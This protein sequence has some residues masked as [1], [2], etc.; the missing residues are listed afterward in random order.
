MQ[1]A[2]YDDEVGYYARPRSPLGA[3]GDYF[4]SPL[5]HPAFA[6]LLARQVRELWDRLGRPR[7]FVL[8]ESG[9]GNGLFARDLLDWLRA[10]EPSLYYGLLYRLD[11]RSPARRREQRRR[12][13]RAEHLERAAW[14]QRFPADPPAH[15]VFANELLDAL[16]VHLVRR[17]DGQP[18]E[19]YVGLERDRLVLVSGPLSTDRLA[20]Y[21]DRLGL[22]PAE[23][24]QAEVNL[25]A[26]DWLESAARGL[27]SGLLLV[28]DY[29]YPAE[30]LYAA[31]RPAGT[32]LSY[33]RHTLGSDPLVRVG[34]QDLTSH[35][36]FTSLRLTAEQA[37]LTTLGLISQRRLLANLGL[38]ELFERTA[39]ADLPQA[40]RD[41]NL[42]ALEALVE[43][44]GL[45]RVLAYFAVKQLDDYAPLGLI[46]AGGRWEPPGLPLRRPDHLRLPGPE[47][48]EG[49]PDFEAQWSEFWSRSEAQ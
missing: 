23:G 40:E 7:P 20:A 15:L 46:G 42:R 47:S 39:A 9:P 22:L 45:G 44:D 49:L 38:G 5:L 28:L 1:L 48:L 19:R 37:G 13:A 34:Q 32:L 10:H 26:L 6:A 36:D 35:V 31:D 18:R 2:L 8:H 17:E 25:A 30:R 29:G 3:E 24:A 12:L 16:P 33:Y 11:E 27:G 14:V 21:F 43:P 4:T 41:A